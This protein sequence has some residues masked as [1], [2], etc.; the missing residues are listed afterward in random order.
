[1]R[2]LLDNLERVEYLGNPLRK[3][4]DLSCEGDEKFE[5]ASLNLPI[6]RDTKPPGARPFAPIV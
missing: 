1:M 5:V 2:A 3:V 4:A 6:I